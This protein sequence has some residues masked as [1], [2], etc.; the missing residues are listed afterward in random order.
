MLNLTRIMTMV[1]TTAAI[2][3]AAPA[4]NAQLFMPNVSGAPTVT[5]DRQTKQERFEGFVKI[6]GGRELYVDFLRPES[7]KPVAVLVNGLTYR[8]GSWDAF[9]TE[10]AGNGIGILRY[11]PAGMGRTLIKDGYPDKPISY[12]TQVRDLNSLLS[13][14]GIRSK[15]HLV[16]LSY[17]G[18]LGVQFAVDYPKKVASL[19]L[20]APFTRPL[21]SQDQMI[22][23][24]VAWNR[25]MFPMN[26]AT[27]DE[28]YDYF[29]KEVVYAQYP[30]VEPI[31]LEHPFKLEATF[32]MVQGVR[33]FKAA[34]IVDLLPDGVVHLVVAKQDQYINASVHE[35]LWNQLPKRTRASR[36][37]VDGS[38]HKI[39]EAV[40]HYSAQWVKL[41][42]DRDSRIQSGRTWD[43]AFWTNRVDSGATRITFP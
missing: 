19:V 42:I 16:T 33:T 39:P 9:A 14:L 24:K 40:P 29:L 37:M 22:R 43:G 36:L 31:V 35:E 4:V 32:R 26:P 17:G 18:A 2:A 6:R 3:L 30:F 20:M 10:L 21:D 13:K 41:V 7:G 12:V 11:D 8:T 23:Q 38:E 28:L 1:A 15:V 25:A 5:T 27:D 34:D